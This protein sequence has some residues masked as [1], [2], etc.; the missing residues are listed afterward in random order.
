MRSFVH[1]QH[2]ST[3]NDLRLHVDRVLR[4]L[5]RQSHTTCLHACQ[6]SARMYVCMYRY[7]PKSNNSPRG[8]LWA[9]G[10]R[11]WANYG[12]DMFQYSYLTS[13]FKALHNHSDEQLAAH[14]ASLVPRSALQKFAW[15]RSRNQQV[16]WV[17]R[18][19]ACWMLTRGHAN[20]SVNCCGRTR[21][22]HRR[23]LACRS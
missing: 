6:V 7:A 20:A 13:R 23:P 21:H 17:A 9:D 10:R 3:F 14:Y 12:A 22:R 8:W 18:V 2:S 5:N 11:Y 16:G 4:V 1:A 15:R 19:F